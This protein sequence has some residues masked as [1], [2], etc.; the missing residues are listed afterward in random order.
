[1]AH[2]NE[3]SWRTANI[4]AT[5]W[6][7]EAENAAGDNNGYPEFLERIRTQTPIVTKGKTRNIVFAVAKEEVC[8]N[9][10]RDHVHLYLCLDV[11]IDGETLKTWMKCPQVHLEKRLG[12]HT[13]AINYVEKEE[14]TKPNGYRFKVGDETKGESK[15]GKRTDLDNVYAAIKAGSTKRKI[16]DQHFTTCV[17]YGKGIERAMTVLG[18]Q[19]HTFKPKEVWILWGDSG[20]GKTRFARTCIIKEEIFVEPAKN[21]AGQLSFENASGDEDFI[22]LDEFTGGSQ[23]SIDTLKQISD[24]YNAILPGRG[25]SVLSKARGVILLSNSDPSTWYPS[26]APQ[27]YTALWRRVTQ[28]FECRTTG[29]MWA[30]PTKLGEDLPVPEWNE[31][32]TCTIEVTNGKPMLR[33]PPL[34]Q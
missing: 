26:A 15:Q 17:R 1:M 20:I 31:D 3:L 8:P 10:G 2:Y 7:P 23:L 14:T 21:N 30:H 18:K 28:C 11:A 27:H 33:Q 19:D 6:R 22:L 25:S 4:C 12:T 16:F 5:I 13:Q 29:W 24:G 9:T 34:P 32:G